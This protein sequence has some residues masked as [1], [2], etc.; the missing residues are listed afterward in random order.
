MFCLWTS[1]KDSWL[2]LWIV[3][4]CANKRSYG[5]CRAM[6]TRRWLPVHG[7]VR[8][9]SLTTI[10]LLPD[11]KQMRMSVR[12]VQVRILVAKTALT[13]FLHQSYWWPLGN[14]R[15]FVCWQSSF[16]RVCI[17]HE[18][19]LVFHLVGSGKI[20]G[21]QGW[22]WGMSVISLGLFF[23][24]SYLSAT[25][26]SSPL[27]FNLWASK[28]FSGEDTE[29]HGTSPNLDFANSSLSDLEEAAHKSPGSMHE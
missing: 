10:E 23:F 25:V 2:S 13:A 24:S 1:R 8:R 6:G 15:S 21:E 20:R 12:S 9:T 16:P 22:C 28:L 5:S 27:L 3:D 19:L 18:A 26:F 7:M 4:V 14:L 11:F 29:P 17:L